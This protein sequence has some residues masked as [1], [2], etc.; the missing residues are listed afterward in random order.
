MTTLEGPRLSALTAYVYELMDR[1]PELE[2]DALS[3]MICDRVLAPELVARLEGVGLSCEYAMDHFFFSC[4]LRHPTITIGRVAV[5]GSTAKALVY[6]GAKG[7][8]G[9]IFEIGLVKTSQGWRVARESA[10]RGRGGGSACR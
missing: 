1:G 7:Q 3:S 5:N 9:G 4:K 10:E 8:S 6:A 2:R